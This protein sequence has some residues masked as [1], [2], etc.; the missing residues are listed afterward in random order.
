MIF[1]LAI[2]G[3]IGKRRASMR[4]ALSG[5]RMEWLLG[6]FSDSATAAKHCFLLLLLKMVD[7]LCR[8]TTRRAAHMDVRRFQ[9]SQG[10]R[11]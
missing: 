4:A 11:V 9:P 2:H 8:V 5:L 10:W 7:A 3:S 6:I 1:R